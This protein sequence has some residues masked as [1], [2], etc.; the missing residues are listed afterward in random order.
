MGFHLSILSHLYSHGCDASI[1]PSLTNYLLSEPSFKIIEKDHYICYRCHISHSTVFVLVGLR[2]IMG[3]NTQKTPPSHS[4]C[5]HPEG[6]VS[7]VCWDC[8]EEGHVNHNHL[9]EGNVSPTWQRLKRIRTSFR[10]RKNSLST[11]KESAAPEVH[12]PEEGMELGTP[13]ARKQQPGLIVVDGPRI[14]SPDDKFRGLKAGRNK[15]RW[16]VD[17]GTSEKNDASEKVLGLERRTFQITIAIAFIVIAALI[18]GVA[19]GVTKHKGSR[20]TSFQMSGGGHPTASST[21]S[22]SAP[23]ATGTSSRICIGDDNSTYIDPGTGSKFQLEC[24]TAHRGKDIENIE[25]TSMQDC[26]GLCAKN[27]Q[28]MGA[29]WYNVGPQGTDLNYCW[30]KSAM[31]DDL[32]ETPDAQSVIRL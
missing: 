18:V 10:T 7:P 2:G 30:L 31:E 16:S 8:A 32:D 28:C 29:I 15:S 20:S 1:I 25:A 12:Q 27:D 6:K 26:I 14:V 3:N 11:A 21:A 23:T 5:P 19:L 17:S 24:A 22:S 13:D 4:P 9:E